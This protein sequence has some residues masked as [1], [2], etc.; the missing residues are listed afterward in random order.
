MTFAND[1]SDTFH[2]ALSALKDGGGPKDYLL[3]VGFAGWGPGQLESELEENA[4]ITSPFEHDLLFELPYENRYS[5]AFSSLGFDGDM[6][7]FQGGEA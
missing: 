7:A 1:G 4:W 5:Q 3:S 6:L 2:E